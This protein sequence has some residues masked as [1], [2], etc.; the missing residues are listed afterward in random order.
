MAGTKGADVIYT[1]VWV[2]MGEPDDVWASRIEEL[3][4]YQVNAKLMENA[5][6]QVKFMHCLPHSMI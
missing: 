4:P 3:T 2:S 1:D 5:G 6:P